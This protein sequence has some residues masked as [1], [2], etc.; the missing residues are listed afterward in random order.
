MWA[1]LPLG[2]VV[3][4][5]R[6]RGFHESTD[7]SL[8]VSRGKL[9]GWRRT[10]RGGNGKSG[11]RSGESSARRGIRCGSAQVWQ[12]STGFGAVR[13]RFVDSQADLAQFGADSAILVR[14]RRARGADSAIVGQIWRFGCFLF[15]ISHGFLEFSAEGTECG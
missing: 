6:L 7:S 11:E 14:I 4:L 12:F 2:H 5:G 1:A 15:V 10:T 3:G 13:G 8:E 9:K